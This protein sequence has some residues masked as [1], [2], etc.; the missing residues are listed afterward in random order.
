MNAD[1]NETR[2]IQS[3][4]VES[5]IEEAKEYDRYAVIR[6]DNDWAYARTLEVANQ[7]KRDMQSAIDRV[8]PIN[9]AVAVIGLP[10]ETDE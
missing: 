9:H 3:H 10:G 7:L 2:P 6:S 5:A 1:T 4:V 8:S